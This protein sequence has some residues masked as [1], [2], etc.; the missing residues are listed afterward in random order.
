MLAEER[1][2]YLYVCVICTLSYT[3]SFVFGVKID[4][5]LI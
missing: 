3:L 5:N 4:N 1:K 2:A